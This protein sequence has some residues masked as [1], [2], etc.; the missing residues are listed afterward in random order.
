MVECH[1]RV[2]EI[3]PALAAAAGSRALLWSWRDASGAL[4][5]G[6]LLY[7]TALWVGGGGV[8]ELA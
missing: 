3:E 7:V 5:W 8:S 2:E 6:V 4:L 1:D